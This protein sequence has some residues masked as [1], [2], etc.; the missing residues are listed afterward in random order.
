[1]VRSVLDNMVKYWVHALC[2]AELR[3][4]YCSC[5][6]KNVHRLLPSHMVLYVVG[7]T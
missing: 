1:M 2:H 4:V 6:D 5:L 3:I 7:S